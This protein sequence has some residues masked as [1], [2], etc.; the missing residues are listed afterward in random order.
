MN[1]RWRAQPD[2]V[3]GGWCVTLEDDKR[4]PAEGAVQLAD[5]VVERTAKHIAD[6]H[7]TWLVLYQGAVRAKAEGR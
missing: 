4:T 1:A 6:C 3:I 5:F 7:N 2:D